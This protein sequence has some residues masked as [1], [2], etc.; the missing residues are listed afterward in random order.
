MKDA[1]LPRLLS[2]MATVLAFALPA[3]AQDAETG[4]A[5]FYDYCSACH[6]VDARGEGPLA[7][8]L[9]IQPPDLTRLSERAGGTFPTLSVVTRIDGRNPL[10]AHGGEM[11]V[12]GRHFE[13]DDTPMKTQAGQPILTSRPIVDLVTWLESVQG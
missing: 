3:S 2:V 6:G 8:L 5:L 7:E 12:F 11:P 10:L 4:A 1:N 13:G 9:K